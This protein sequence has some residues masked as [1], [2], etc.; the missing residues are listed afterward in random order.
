[1]LVMSSKTAFSSFVFKQK[2][3]LKYLF[4]SAAKRISVGTV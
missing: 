1:M 3:A 4:A 2:Q